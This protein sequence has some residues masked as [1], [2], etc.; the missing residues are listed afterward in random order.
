MGAPAFVAGGA[1]CTEP[2]GVWERTSTFENGALHLWRVGQGLHHGETS[3]LISPNGPGNGL[4]TSAF[5]SLRLHVR[6]KL[7][8]H[9]PATNNLPVQD[10]P[11]C[12]IQGTEC[13]VMLE[14]ISS[15]DLSN[16]SQTTSWHH[17]FYAVSDATYK[18]FCDTC[19]VAHER[20]NSDVW[21]F[22]DSGDLRPQL[23]G[24]KFIKQISV[25][26]SGHQYDVAIAEVTLLGGP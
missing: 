10:V 26:A 16:P 2:A 6:I 5:S 15:S 24:D 9:D 12:G 3:C 17:G 20:V 7:V 22:Y 11:V 4:D 19:R 25:Y 13:P 14:I 23:G 18:L 8:A 1:W 21:Y